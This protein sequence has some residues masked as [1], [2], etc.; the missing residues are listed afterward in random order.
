MHTQL[1]IPFARGSHTSFKAARDIA[2]AGTRPTKTWR[3][4]QALAKERDG[5]IDWHAAAVLNVPVSSICSI[6]SGCMHNLPA[7]VERGDEAMGG[8][9][10]RVYKWK[11]TA[12]GVTLMRSATHA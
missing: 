1:G 9:G 10:K 3:Y 11:L 8:Y 4:L 7:L 5:L 2:A 6:R 12:A